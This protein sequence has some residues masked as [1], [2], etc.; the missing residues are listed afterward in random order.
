M[1]A[2]AA[3]TE[4]VKL[5]P[6]V[7][8]VARRRPQVLARQAATLDRLS[9]GRLIFGA[10]LGGDPGGE[11]TKFGEELDPK[12]RAKLLDDGLDLLDSWWRGDEA[13]GA[14]LLPTPVQ[15]PRIPIWLASRYPNAQPVRRAARWDGLFPVAL[16]QPTDLTELLDIASQADADVGGSFDVAVQGLPGVDP[17]PWVDAGATWWLV[18]FE[19]WSPT[20]DEVRRV[21]EA[22]PPRG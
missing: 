16:E 22:G 4:R 20:Y 12:A 18:R 15:R 14:R 17:A 1:A 3:A 19:P 9:N 21:I 13:M 7:T 8:P 11:L 6:M 10:G 2:M 5:G